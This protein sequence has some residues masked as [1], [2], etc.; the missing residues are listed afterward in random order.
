MKDLEGLMR[1]WVWVKEWSFKVA[2]RVSVMFH[3][4]QIS[5]KLLSL[6]CWPILILGEE[7][8]DCKVG[9]QYWLTSSSD[10]VLPDGVW[11][12]PKPKGSG[13]RVRRS[14]WELSALGGRWLV[15]PWVQKVLLESQGSE[16]PKGLKF[17]AELSLAQKKGLKARHFQSFVNLMYQRIVLM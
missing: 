1:Y 6:F 16:C 4:L 13:K 2:R 9:G 17:W 3:E 14:I 5:Y 7:E 8:W 11:M 12:D 15:N 10:W